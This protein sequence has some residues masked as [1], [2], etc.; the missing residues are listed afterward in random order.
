[1]TPAGAALLRAWQAW[2]LHPGAVQYARAMENTC[3]AFAGEEPT[4]G[5]R[6]FLAAARRRGVSRET[7][8]VAWEDLHR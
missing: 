5:L 3:R 2:D 6:R 4:L 8:I 1:M 7:A